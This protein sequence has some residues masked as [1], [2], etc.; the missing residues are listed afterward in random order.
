M[1]TRSLLIKL[2]KQFPKSIAKKHHDF[3]GLMVGKLPTEVHKILLCLDFDDEVLIQ[4]KQFQPDLILTHHPFIYGRK[5]FVL[6]NDL[7]K[8]RLYEELEKLNIPVYSM[9]TNFDEGKGGMNDALMEKL[10]VTDVY[11]SQIEPMMR[12]AKLKKPAK[13][14]EIAKI[15]KDKFNIS[16]GLLCGRDDKLINSIALIAGGGSRSWINAKL[17]GAD[18]YISG[19]APH[20]VRRDIIINDYVY[21]DLPHEIEKIFMPTMKNI[22]LNIDSSLQILVVDHEIEPLVI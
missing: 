17:E 15:I 20:H 6:K 5:S 7:I 4:A 12:I 13:S 2:S 3:V 11:Q 22:L 16:Y 1:N 21:L 19:D 10:D 9:H 18:M 8:K 14:K